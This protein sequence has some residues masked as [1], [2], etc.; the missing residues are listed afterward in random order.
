[1][2]PFRAPRS[3][4][5]Q[6]SAVVDFVLISGL[7][8]LLFLGVLQLTL[9]LHVRNSLIDAASSGA[10]YGA[11]ADRVPDDAVNRARE[12]IT[13]AVGPGFAQDITVMEAREGANTLLTVTVRA[14][15]PVIGLVGP[16][17]VLEVTGHAEHVE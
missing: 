15:F 17:R 16:D 1:M 2:R 8:T 5:E 12:L 6:G 10:R 9:I 11:L 14:P 3:C 13:G 4:Q 7:L